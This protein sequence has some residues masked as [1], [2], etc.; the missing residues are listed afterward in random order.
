MCKREVTKLNK[1]NFPAWKSLM[2]LHIFGIRDIAWNSVEK[3]YVDPTRTLTAEQLKARKEHNQ[4]MLEI[5]FAL[6]Y[7][8]YEDVKACANAKLMWDKLATIYGCDT[9]VKR[10]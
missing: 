1:E 4:A 6:S 10:A 3:A 7:F 9:N 5:A 8:E 2:K